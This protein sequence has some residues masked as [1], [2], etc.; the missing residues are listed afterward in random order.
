MTPISSLFLWCSP[1]AISGFIVAVI[2]YS[3]DAMFL[4]RSASHIGKKVQIGI[5]PTLANFDST[6]AIVRILEVPSVATTIFNVSPASIFRGADSVIAFTMYALKGVWHR[7]SF[8]VKASTRLAL[9]FDKHPG[10][11]RFFIAALATANPSR[12]SGRFTQI[13][14]DNGPSSKNAACKLLDWSHKY[15]YHICQIL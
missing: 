8:A 3:M 7:N 12:A 11:N 2:I 9:P 6:S 4:R 13:L 1:F 15:I 14:F 10:F 5:K